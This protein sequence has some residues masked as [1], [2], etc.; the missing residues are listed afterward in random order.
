MPSATTQ[1]AP[2]LLKALATLLDTTVRTLAVDR[3][4]LKLYWILDKIPHFSR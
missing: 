2:D 1:A 3:E 4:Y